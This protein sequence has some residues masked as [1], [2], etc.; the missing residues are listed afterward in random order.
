MDA[1]RAELSDRPVEIDPPSPSEM[2]KFAL[3]SLPGWSALLKL[4]PKNETS[5]KAHLRQLRI[6]RKELEVKA[7]AVE[8]EEARAEYLPPK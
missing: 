4:D 7:Q 6:E 5:F 2:I 1:L 8:A 3:Q